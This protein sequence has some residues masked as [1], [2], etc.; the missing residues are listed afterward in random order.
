MSE[1][2]RRPAQ[3]ADVRLGSDAD[4]VAAALFSLPIVRLSGRSTVATYLP[5]RRVTGV[6]VGTDR[7]EVHIALVHP[8]T[9][10]EGAAAVRGALAGVVPGPVDVVVDDVLTADQ[11]SPESA[12]AERTETDLQEVGHA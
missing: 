12:R 4:A 11:L 1:L 6:R 9:V 8:T 5:G 7:T 10:E 2:A 3:G